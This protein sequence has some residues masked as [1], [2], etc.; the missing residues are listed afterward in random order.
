M[1]G[2]GCGCKLKFLAHGFAD[3]LFR[4]IR[5]NVGLRL[6]EHRLR[7]ISSMIGTA[8]GETRSSL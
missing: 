2:A 8:S 5:Q 7:P 3:Q 1:C 4:R 6:A